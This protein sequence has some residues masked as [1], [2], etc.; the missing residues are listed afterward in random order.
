MESFE[1]LT[2]NLFVPKLMQI[3]APEKN[4]WQELPQ[5]LQYGN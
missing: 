3:P 4:H 5:S 2:L 1:G